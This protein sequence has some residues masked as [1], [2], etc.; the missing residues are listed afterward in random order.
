MFLMLDTHQE[1]IGQPYSFPTSQLLLLGQSSVVKYRSI[2]DR[3]SSRLATHVWDGGV[4]AVEVVVVAIGAVAVVVAMVVVVASASCS[5]KAPFPVEAGVG[6]AEEIM[7]FLFSCNAQNTIPTINPA[8]ISAR[9][10]MRALRHSGVIFFLGGGEEGGE[11][12]E[13]SFVVIAVAAIV[14]SEDVW[15]CCCCCYCSWNDLPPWIPSILG[16]STYFPQQ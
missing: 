2:A 8:N 5:S 16:G 7:S 9:S 4:V 10:V 1:F 11:R 6:G 12:D 3:S 14:V 13:S 15:W